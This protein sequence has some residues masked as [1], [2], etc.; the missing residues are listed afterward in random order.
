MP[1]FSSIEDVLT[2]HLKGDNIVF[3][4]E[5]SFLEWGIFQK[6]AFIFRIGP[7]ERREGKDGN[8]FLVRWIC[9]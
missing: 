9:R 4:R 7:G 6:T 3:L 2:A 8:V 1:F 5:R